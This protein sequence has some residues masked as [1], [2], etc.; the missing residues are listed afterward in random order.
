[1]VRQSIL[2]LFL[3]F[4]PFIQSKKAIIIGASSGIG[5]EVSRQLDK[6]GYTLGLVAR[7]KSLLESLQKELNQPS[8]T[9]AIDVTE[10]DARTKLS[11]LIEQ[12]NGVDLVLISITA[13]LDNRNHSSPDHV[14]YTRPDDWENKERTLDVDCKGFIA[15]AD[16]AFEHFMTQN[17]GHFVG[18]SSTSGL[19]G[20]S[21]DP[22]YSASKA[23][24]STYMEG[25]RNQMVRDNLNVTVT[26]IVPG[27]V[28]V[29]HSPLGEDPTAY[30]EIP[31]EE[32]GT[33]IMQGI[34]AKKK[35]VYVPSKVWIMSV[36]RHLPDRI[37]HRY[38]NWMT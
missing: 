38:F 30:W 26:A 12:M 14:D 15:L 10:K 9:E 19:K 8:Y 13:Y 32:A 7:R 16:V 34:L 37:L 17:S 29:E 3:C 5:R 1:M 28:A 22:V 18:I 20:F 33:A 6:H 21:V 24:I 35:T 11:N 2:L 4:T 23:S 31:V 36:L 27:F 25:M